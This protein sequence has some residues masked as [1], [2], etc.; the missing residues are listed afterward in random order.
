VRPRGTVAVMYRILA[1]VAC[2]GMAGAVYAEPGPADLDRTLDAIAETDPAALRAALDR[3]RNDAAEAS[4]EAANLREKADAVDAESKRLRALLDALAPSLTRDEAV[5]MAAA[6]PKATVTFVD[7]VQPIFESRCGRCHN[8]D[9]REGGLSLANHTL[10]LEGGSSGAVLAAG[11]PAGS[12]LLRL[13]LQEEEPNMPPRGNPLDAAQIDTLRQWIALGMP[14]NAG[15]EVRVAKASSLEVNDDAYVAAAVVD[16]PPPMPEVGLTALAGPSG[17][18]A[19]AR[20]VAASPTAPLLAAG[21]R[22]QILLYDVSQPSPELLGALPFP[23]G[24]AY[25]LTFSLN[26]ELLLA[27][28]GENGVAGAAVIWNVRKGERLGSYGRA[29]DSYYAADL[30]PDHGMVALGGPSKRVRVYSVRDGAMLYELTKHTDWVYAIKFSPD[31]ELLASADRAGNL[32]LWQA[33]NGR[34]VDSLDGHEGAINALAYTYDSNV[35]ASAG[36]DGKI[37]LWDTWKYKRIRQIDAK[38]GEV[39][40]VAISRAGEIL[41]AGTNGA[42]RRWG[43]DGKNIIDYSNVGDWSYAAGFAHDDTRVFAGA[44]TGEAVVR[45]TESGEVAA[46]LTTNPA[47]DDSQ[48]GQLAKK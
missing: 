46:T 27:A 31:G 36:S 7:H 44:W 40:D 12:R 37:M 1:L 22:N 25:A 28:G 26:G 23:E 47:P 14:E 33:A 5:A 2:I 42:L 21:G 6:E 34:A 20:A 29:Y 35:L 18:P 11:D 41:S 48:P 39:L 10:A 13:V 8:L 4:V 45:D 43:L 24:E 9:R 32:L 19:P 17:R 38:Q 16:G 30:S 15:S 3:L